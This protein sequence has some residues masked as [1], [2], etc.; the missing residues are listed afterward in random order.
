MSSAR[1]RL[2]AILGDPVA[3]SL[4]PAMHT[5]A[6]RTLGLDAEYVAL[7]CA[8]ADVP[9]AMRLLARNGGGGN[10]TVPFKA[11]A[12]AAVAR[13]SE[14]V[15]ALGACNTF[16]GADDEVAGDN[17]DVEGVL[18]AVERLGVP[19]GPWLLAG[20]GGSA[21]AVAAAAA[22]RGATL[23]VRSRSPARAA[24]FAAWAAGIGAAAAPEELAVLAV[25]AT[26]LGLHA[27]DPLPLDVARHPA[28]GAVLDLVYARGG[29]PL[30]RAARARGLPAADGRAMLV[31]QGAAAFE[32]WF[33]GRRAPLDAMQAAVDAHL[34]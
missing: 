31:A 23:A 28:V 24:E 17:T 18:R 5:A 21:R 3:H 29:T 32:R 9:L 22:A 12:A 1:T 33:P 6:F 14:L 8:A 15:R 19:D 30:V 13:P 7:R 20:T 11:E 16:W 4:S 34:G 2:F 26:P 27:R 25:N 10:V